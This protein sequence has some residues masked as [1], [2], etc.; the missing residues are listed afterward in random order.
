M[1]RSLLIAFAAFC[2]SSA[3]WAEVRV[4][5]YEAG[6][7]S[8]PELNPGERILAGGRENIDVTYT[9]PAE[10][11]VKFG[12][13]YELSG[14]RASG[15]VVKYIYLT[16]GV[17]EPDGTRHDKYEVVQ[18]LAAQAANHTAAFEFTERYEVVPGTWELL[19]FENDRLL[20]RKTFE[21]TIEVE[22]L[23]TRLQKEPS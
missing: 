17:V 5:E 12:V 23:S 16:P 18:E 19:V 6:V 13:R 9:V 14:K 7:F 3:A 20:L 11:G 8:R 10:V 2:F 22:D 21:V 4:T 15:N 1:N